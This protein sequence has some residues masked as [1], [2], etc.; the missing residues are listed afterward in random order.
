MKKTVIGAALCLASVLGTGGSVF[1]GEVTGGPTPKATGMEGHANSYCG[2]SGIEDHPEATDGM[3]PGTP[4][5]ATGNRRLTQTP[6]LVWL[7]EE[8]GVPV[9]GWYNPPH[10]SP[11]FN[12]EINCNPNGPVVPHNN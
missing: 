2:F 7:T 10:G 5:G 6:H 11:A 8:E 9:D 4:A 1:A 12:A 3:P